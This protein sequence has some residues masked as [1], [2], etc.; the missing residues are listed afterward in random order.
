MAEMMIP[1]RNERIVYDRNSPFDYMQDNHL[2]E[3]Y[4]FPKHV[5]D[6]IIDLVKDEFRFDQYMVL[7]RHTSS[8]QIVKIILQGYE[9]S[10]NVRIFFHGL[11]T[12]S[13]RIFARLS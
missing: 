5:L 10:Y 9:H 3:K 8:N 13:L 12:R 1:W 4:R 6:E 7:V 2:M 11:V